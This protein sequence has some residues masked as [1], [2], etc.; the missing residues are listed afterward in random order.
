MLRHNLSLPIT[1]QDLLAQTID[2]VHSGKRRSHAETLSPSILDQLCYFRESA[3]ALQGPSSQPFMP[4]DAWRI[5][6]LTQSRRSHEFP[7]H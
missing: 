1:V 7:L 4:V 3:H 2:Y 5:Y 6:M